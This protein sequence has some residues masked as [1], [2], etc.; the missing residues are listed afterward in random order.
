MA[1]VHASY[2]VTLKLPRLRSQVAAFIS[3]FASLLRVIETTGGGPRLNLQREDHTSV[4]LTL[5]TTTIRG[6]KLLSELNALLREALAHKCAHWCDDA[7]LA[8]R[9]TS[10][11]W[12]DYERALRYNLSD[13][14][15]S[16]LVELLSLSS[17]YRQ[18]ST[19][20]SAAVRRYSYAASTSSANYLYTRQWAGLH[21]K[22][23]S[24]RRRRSSKV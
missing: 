5:V 1:Q 4:C 18:P 13:I 9:C 15:R 17:R 22:R 23:S 7:T 3:E 2:D 11:E 8:K 12:C 20:S 21:V 24:T 14:E 6:L 16:A 10:G 19:R